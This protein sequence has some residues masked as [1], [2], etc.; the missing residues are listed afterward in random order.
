MSLRLDKGHADPRYSQRKKEP[1]DSLEH[2]SKFAKRHVRLV[3]SHLIIAGLLPHVSC[4]R[5]A[6]PL[7]TVQLAC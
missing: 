5:H 2:E 6:N 4:Q 7:T 1:L 3:A